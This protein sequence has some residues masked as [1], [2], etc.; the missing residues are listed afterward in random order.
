MRKYMYQDFGRWNKHIR[1]LVFVLS[2]LEF[3]PWSRDG[4]SIMHAQG[5]LLEW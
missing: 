5:A 3:N 1:N 4:A 2:C